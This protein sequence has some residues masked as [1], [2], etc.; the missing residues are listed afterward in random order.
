M[1]DAPQATSGVAGGEPAASQHSFA[2]IA[3]TSQQPNFVQRAGQYESQSL[4]NSFSDIGKTLTTA[5][6]Q[7]KTA[8]PAWLQD[9]GATAGKVGEDIGGIVMSPVI[10][11]AKAAVEPAAAPF[12]EF[13]AGQLGS[14]PEQAKVFGEKNK[15]QTTNVLGGA[16]AGS[17][18]IG[19]G[20]AELPTEPVVIKD[21][22]DR[23]NSPILDSTVSKQA[24]DDALANLSMKAKQPWKKTD[25]MA[26]DTLANA[27]QPRS[28]DEIN[29]D[30]NTYAAKTDQI[31]SKEVLSRL[32]QEKQ[33][34]LNPQN[35][36]DNV[37]RT[38]GGKITDDQFHANIKQPAL[39]AL[40]AGVPVERVKA[41]L[42]G[43]IPKTFDDDY[44]QELIDKAIPQP[45]K[46]IAAASPE[47][48]TAAGVKPADVQGITLPNTAD[49]TT[50]N[51][52]REA[53][54]NTN[55][56]NADQT[57]K[58]LGKEGTWGQKFKSAYNG[59]F[60]EYTIMDN[61]NRAWAKL[62]DINIGR[63]DILELSDTA[64]QK[65]ISQRGG[66]S[67]QTYLGDLG[68]ESQS[69]YRIQPGTSELKE[70]P[71]IQPYN[72]VKQNAI[73]AGLDPETLNKINLTRNALD[74]Y[75]N[76]DRV[77][78][79]SVK[80]IAENSKKVEVL[81]E[82]QLQ[83]ENQGFFANRKI[84]NQM[85]ILANENKAHNKL[86]TELGKKQTYMTREDALASHATYKDNPAATQYIDGLNKLHGALLDDLVTAGKITPELAQKL[87]DTHPNY[88]PAFRTADDYTV[89][90]GGRGYAGGA[91]KA[92]VRREI[93]KR[94]GD[95]IDVEGNIV[96]NIVSSI[97]KRD[98]AQ[99]RGVMLDNLTK[100]LDD[101]GWEVAFREPKQ[102]VLK[103]M[104]T[105]KSTDAQALMA[106]DITPP[107]P[108][109]VENYNHIVF[110]VNGKQLQLS[111]KDENL[112]KSL[113]HEYL[114]YDPK[115]L[116]LKSQLW[117]SRFKRAGIIT[118]D[119]T[120]PIRNMERGVMDF[121]VNSRK[122]TP[123]VDY[124]PGIS[125][126]KT[127]AGTFFDKKFY[128]N[129]SMNYGFGNKL[130]KSYE[131]KSTDNIVDMIKNNKMP[132]GIVR[133][134]FGG[135]EDLNNR[136]DAGTRILQF[137]VLKAKLLAE[138]VSPAKAYEA[139]MMAS[140]DVHLNFAQKGASNNLNTVMQLVPLSRTFVNAM[141]KSLRMGQY[142]PLT[143]A[144]GSA[145][146]FVVYKAVQAWNSQYKDKDGIPFDQKLDPEIT[147][148][149]MPI[150]Y[151][152]KPNQYFPWHLGWV[153]GR[154]MPAWNKTWDYTSQYMGKAISGI[155]GDNA[156]KT[157]KQIPEL[158]G[159]ITGKELF[160]AWSNWAFGIIT[161]E[162]STPPILGA[163]IG[164]M[165]NKD[166]F[167]RPIV[168]SN[169]ED[170]GAPAFTKYYNSTDPAMV[171]FTH[172]LYTKYGIDLSPAKAEFVTRE[173]SGTF[174]DTILKSGAHLY[175][176][177]SGKNFPEPDKGDI[178]GFKLFSG[179]TSDVPHE[180]I[181][182]KYSNIY[183]TL[184][185]I[186]EQEQVLKTQA[187]TH[188]EVAPAYQKFVEE[189]STE[190]MWA[191]RFADANKALASLRKGQESIIYADKDTLK[192][193]Q[194][195]TPSF[196]GDKSKRD[197]LDR[198]KEQQIAIQK[199][200]LQGIVDDLDSSTN[201]TNDIWYQRND[202]GLIT[203][204]VDAFLPSENPKPTD[205]K[206][207]DNSSKK[208]YTKDSPLSE[209]LT[210]NGGNGS[211][212]DSPPAIHQEAPQSIQDQ[213]KPGFI[214]QW[215]PNLKHG[216]ENMYKDNIIDY[217][218]K[219]NEG[220]DK[221][222][223]IPGDR[224]GATK[225]GITLK[226]L[227]ESNPKATANDVKNMTEDQAKS[228]YA[229]NYWDDGQVDKMPIG[230][231][232]LVFDMNIN[233]GLGGSAII[234]QRAL[235]DLGAGVDVD[236]KIGNDTLNNMNDF[237]TPELRS[238]ILSERE[239]WVNDIVKND[240]SQAKFLPGWSKRIAGMTNIPDE[241][242]EA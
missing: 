32:Q 234:I 21:A 133:K 221:F 50:P 43:S 210:P 170:K 237:K 233:H 39:D 166:D 143:W 125:Q 169:L 71:S 17:V 91:Q 146:I 3:N 186:V 111:L 239:K 207:L 46:N 86:I 67:Y 59:T 28:V 51:S 121:L 155:S 182:S 101:K 202:R 193:N 108:N 232:D 156:E 120:F 151:G 150:Y 87:K 42:E 97:K 33:D 103:A 201:P 122:V 23:S 164:L 209:W 44:R 5:P 152:N 183:Q 37:A 84:M 10:S 172:A 52:V 53:I 79:D 197:E 144:A 118:L 126:V 64:L 160:D 22:I 12:G 74:D 16:L 131:L 136:V 57:Q 242:K 123:F 154:S 219:Q 184:Q 158:Q 175:S 213:Y 72:T 15:E 135:L 214:E 115:N 109:K 75:A 95:Q 188:P 145:H 191:N 93:G 223:D 240:P 176:A 178:P 41:E 98:A 77:A 90:M 102:D 185:P 230:V 206:P 165:R 63:N 7:D 196:L 112:F 1:L 88:V 8:G 13:V 132:G 83:P 31:G 220:G 225:Y 2:D 187:Q 68:G 11:T 117:I 56:L 226:T 92:V 55:G 238:A 161:P 38:E 211:M 199:G 189:H 116:A 174:G 4:D 167:N 229:K 177:M 113:A 34:A 224:G 58:I 48:A 204:G 141:D 148:D 110:D 137:K 82:A 85:E 20:G 162:S 18:M 216:A 134:T 6:Q 40:N 114:Q 19:A 194:D 66:Y 25:D 190:L 147:K 171:D 130:S 29:A 217:T 69:I 76:L 218:M 127:T 236:G 235:N 227:Q 159:K 153:W 24:Q 228:I 70:D 62:N 96:R 89:T 105:L 139:A 27:K 36:V 138:G 65:N 14:T 106:Q 181:E 200:M 173:L 129:Y 203:R 99:L 128:D 26:A 208:G 222:T 192:G 78:Q 73:K 30:I 9:I 35:V 212:I 104:D 157:I 45:A 231:Q 124:I 49:V 149:V 180:G 107:N 140:K 179:N 47:I 198:L 61:L 241:V 80:Q 54:D 205:A 215:L 94:G 142:A 195:T 119:P 60:N 81:K 163:G 100:V 168:P